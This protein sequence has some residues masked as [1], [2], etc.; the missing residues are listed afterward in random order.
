VRATLALVA[1]SVGCAGTGLIDDGSSLSFGPPNDGALIEGQALPARGDGY[2]M[3]PTW[4]RRGLHFGTA[5][6]VA[7]IVHLG[8]QLNRRRPLAVADLSP[9]SGGPSAWHRSHQTGRDVDL[10]FFARDAAGAPAATATMRRYGPDGA[11]IPDR[12]GDPVVFFDVP[13]NWVLVRA[14][15]ENPIADVQWIFIS[16][17]LKQLLID[18]AIATAAPPDL[19]AAAAVLL[20]QPTRSLPHDDHMHVRI[21]CAPSDVVLGCEETGPYRWY[22]KSY[23]YRDREGTARP[24]AAAVLP[25]RMLMAGLPAL[26]FRGFVAR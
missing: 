11:S 15:I 20:H 22:K 21:Y 17:D 24:T 23:K 19:I 7:V 25:R 5:E 26:P 14:L 1:L 2:A 8:R 16:D 10:I 6:L 12:P 9:R 13:A 3:P 4:A 18:H